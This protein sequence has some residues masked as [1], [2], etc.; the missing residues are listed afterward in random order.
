MFLMSDSLR[1]WFYGH[2]KKGYSQPVLWIM[3][4][5]QIRISM[6]PHHFGNH[7]LDPPPHPHHGKKPDPKPHPD[8]N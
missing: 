4:N 5:I 7:D 2:I 8:P 6:D 3:I 1:G